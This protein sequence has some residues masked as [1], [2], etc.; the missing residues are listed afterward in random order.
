[1]KKTILVFLSTCFFLITNAQEKTMNLSLKEA[2]NFAIENSYNT[3]AAENDIKVAKETVWETTTIGLPQINGA[4]DYQK[5]LKLP[6]TLLDFDNDGV[7]EEFVFVQKQNINASVTLS[8]LLFDGSYLVGLQASKTYLKISKQAKEKTELVT[9]EAIINAYGNVLVAE[10]S[11][12]ILKRNNVVNDRILREAKAGYENGLAEQEDVEQFEIIKGNIEN[13]IRATERLRDIAYKLL[14]ISLGNP[15]ETNLVLTDSLESL[16]LANTNLNLL[17]EEFKLNNHIDF[18]IAEND[19]E[20][21]RLTMQLEK[22]KNLPSLSAYINYGTQAFSEEFSFF[23]GEQRWFQSSLLGVS[24]NVPIFS[25]FGRKAK[26][27]QTKINLETADIRLEETKQRLSLAA[28]SAK[29]DYQLSIDNYETAKKNLNLAERIEKKQQ[30]KFDEGITT[31]F[32]LL[33]AQ[34][35]LYTQQNNYVQAMLNIIA[36][37]ATLENALNLPIK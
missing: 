36:T 20:T 11:I 17:V 35:Q 25:S 16:V 7:N 4:V 10:K 23:K 22:S 14:N 1:M 33:Q 34:N 28:Q 9:R 18:K 21:K 2:I 37:K 13:N 31:S 19:R 6:V 15:I 5:Y 29:S 26:I 3:K 30:I 8:Q 32:D 27:A 12:E 24:L